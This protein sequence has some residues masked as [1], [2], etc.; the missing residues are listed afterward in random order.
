MDLRNILKTNIP[1]MSDKAMPIY[2]F[3]HHGKTRKELVQGA[4]ESLQ[5]YL[6]AED[7]QEEMEANDER[8]HISLEIFKETAEN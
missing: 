2:G 5:A 8:Y 1:F 6:E 4:I 3:H 7:V